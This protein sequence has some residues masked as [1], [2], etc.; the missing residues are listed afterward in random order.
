MLNSFRMHWDLAGGWWPTKDVT[1]RTP[2]SWLPQPRIRF[3]RY[4]DHLSRMM[5]GR[6]S[7]TRILNSA[8]AA[9]GCG[10]ATVITKDHAVSSW[11]FVRLVG[12]LL[13]SPDHMR[14]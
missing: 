9:T 12:A 14:H 1:Y 6:P 2:A 13:D 3:D 8:I 5:L 10:P 4:V 7:T 11:L